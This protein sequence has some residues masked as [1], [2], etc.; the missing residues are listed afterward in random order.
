VAGLEQATGHVYCRRSCKRKRLFARNWG[1]VT[2]DDGPF[3]CRSWCV[4]SPGLDPVGRTVP[5]SRG[6]PG[7]NL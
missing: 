4:T 5:V 3:S 1:F 2:V 6:L 7:G